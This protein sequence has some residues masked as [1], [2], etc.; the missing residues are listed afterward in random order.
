MQVL[1]M[2]CSF[3]SADRGNQALTNSTDYSQNRYPHGSVPSLFVGGDNTVILG[4]S[5]VQLSPEH[6]TAFSNISTSRFPQNPSLVRLVMLLAHMV[7]LLSFSLKL[8][9][10]FPIFSHVFASF[11]SKLKSVPRSVD[12]E[13]SDVTAHGGTIPA[14]KLKR[15]NSKMQKKPHDRSGGSNPENRSDRPAIQ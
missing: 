11:K 7:V 2:V 1:D 6:M 14:G 9:R 15:Q 8:K 3:Q 4:S 5:A 13:G 10:H 12:S